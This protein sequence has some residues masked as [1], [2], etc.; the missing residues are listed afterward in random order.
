MLKDLESRRTPELPAGGVMSGNRPGSVGRPAMRPLTLI[1]ALLVVVLALSLGYLLWQQRPVTPAPAPA[2]V[3]AAQGTIARPATTPSPSAATRATPPPQTTVVTPRQPALVQPSPTPAVTV[4]SRL[5]GIT[6]TVVDGGTAPRTLTLTGEGL[7]G[8]QQIVV[9]WG[10]NEKILPGYRVEWLDGRS[11]RIK[12]ITGNSAAQWRV[13][14]LRPDGSRSPALGFEVRASAEID[15]TS[16]DAP[17]DGQM[18]KTIHQPSASERAD[19]L[20]RQGY[21]ALQQRDSAG[22]ERLW[23]QALTTA[24][25]HLQAREGL[26]ALYLSQGRKVESSKLLQ[27]GVSRHP[28]HAQ[29]VMLHARLLAEQGHTG[30]ALT[31]LEQAI[32]STEPQAELFALAAALYQQQRNYE[33]SVRAYQRA[34]QMQPQQGHWWMGLGIS[35]EGADKPAEAQSAYK[36]ALERGALTTESQQYVQQR[37]QELK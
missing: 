25:A 28:T 24:P 7:G 18:K 11:A 33:Q 19:Q 36:E 27:E 1:L 15:I 14:L 22:A 3:A 13:A 30:E 20:Y 2:S 4:T 23:Q 17:G 31:A 37:L 35:L 34:L 6:P 12:L 16:L 10:D 32:G 26:I 29:F 9:S 8:D 21:L 5:T